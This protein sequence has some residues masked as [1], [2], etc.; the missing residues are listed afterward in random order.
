MMN[1]DLPIKDQGSQIKYQNISSTP[2]YLG[3][4]RHDHSMT[5]VHKM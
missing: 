4:T 3:N 2:F 1:K 5:R